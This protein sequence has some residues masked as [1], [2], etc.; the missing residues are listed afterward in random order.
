MLSGRS[1]SPHDAG[2][3]ADIIAERTLG[4]GQG[5]GGATHNST[6]LLLPCAT[7]CAV[8]GGGELTTTRNVPSGNA[9]V[10][11]KAIVF[12]SFVV[13]HIATGSRGEYRG[14]LVM[15]SSVSVRFGKV[16]TLI[17]LTVVAG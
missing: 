16:D 17:T 10:S 5:Q 11:G 1:A 15:T 12:P 4:G 2:A 14:G 9:A 7:I 8:P 6:P 3:S 13:T